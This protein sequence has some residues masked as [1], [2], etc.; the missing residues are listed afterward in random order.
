MLP[1]LVNESPHWRQVGGSNGI[2]NVGGNYG[3]WMIG[4][5]EDRGTFMVNRRFITTFIFLDYF[6]EN[7]CCIDPNLHRVLYIN[8]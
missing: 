5:D 1:G 8:I 7:C 4:D 6:V 3:W 2:W